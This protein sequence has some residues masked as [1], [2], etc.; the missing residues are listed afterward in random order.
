M[1]TFIPVLCREGGD[2]LVTST[3]PSLTLSEK[4]DF[5]GFIAD[6]T[7]VSGVPEL[8]RQ[9]RS[10]L[11]GSIG[12]SQCLICYATAQLMTTILLFENNN[13]LPHVQYFYIDFGLVLLPTV[14][15]GL[16][17]ATRDPLSD[18]IPAR[19]WM[20]WRFVTSVLTQLMLIVASQWFALMMAQNQPWFKS[21]RQNPESNASDSDE[22]YAIYSLSLFQYLSLFFV[23]SMG[24]PYRLRIWTNFPLT[25][26]LVLLGIISSLVILD[27]PEQLQQWMELKVAPEFDFRLAIFSLAVIYFIF[28]SAIQHFIDYLI[29]LC[30]RPSSADESTLPQSNGSRSVALN[31]LYKPETL[32]SPNPFTN[33]L[34]GQ[35]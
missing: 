21:L 4:S 10:A 9:C 30:S 32:L 16:T 8:I 29:G 14:L 1:D 18:R 31:V 11:V 6:A 15:F 24:P 17:R 13:A 23:F 20:D 2:C 22:N 25:I 3:I 5:S 26:T 35:F 27:P 28:S 7:N 12:I 34:N 19:K 33:S